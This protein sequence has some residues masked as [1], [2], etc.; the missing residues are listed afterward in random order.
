MD[1]VEEYLQTLESFVASG[2]LHSQDINTLQ[3]R[4]QG[5]I[6]PQTPEDQSVQ[7]SIMAPLTGFSLPL[8]SPETDSTFTELINKQLLALENNLK[9]TIPEL[10]SVTTADLNEKIRQL[11]TSTN[12]T[13][14]LL[15]VAE[16]KNNTLTATVRTLETD[17]NNLEHKI[18]VMEDTNVMLNNTKNTL[19]N[20]ISTL[21]GSNKQLT[22]T[23]TLK[24][25]TLQEAKAELEVKIAKDQVNIEQ[26]NAKFTALQAEID[27]LKSSVSV[28][29]S[30][31]QPPTNPAKKKQ[32]T[33]D[34]EKKQP[35]TNAE[36][37]LKEAETKQAQ[38]VEVLTQEKTRQKTAAADKAAAEK[39]AADKAAAEKA[40]AEKAA[41]D[42][43][44]AEKAAA[45]NTEL[46]RYITALTKWYD[47]AALFIYQYK[48]GLKKW[49]NYSFNDLISILR[50][51]IEKKINEDTK[52]LNK[53]TSEYTGQKITDISSEHFK[54]FSTLFDDNEKTMLVNNDIVIPSSTIEYDYTKST[55]N[56]H[57]KAGLNVLTLMLVDVTSGLTQLTTYN[58]YVARLYLYTE[59]TKNIVPLI[60]EFIVN[61][62]PLQQIPKNQVDLLYKS[63]TDQIHNFK[64]LTETINLS[65]QSSAVLPTAGLYYLNDDTNFTILKYVAK[66]I[67][68]DMNQSIN[69]D[70]EKLQI[71]STQVKEV[72]KLLATLKTHQ[73]ETNDANRTTNRNLQNN[74][75][76]LLVNIS[77]FISNQMVTTPSDYLDIIVKTILYPVINLDKIKP[78]P[79][80]PR[81]VVH[82]YNNIA[83]LVSLW[84]IN[85]I[86]EKIKTIDMAEYSVPTEKFHN[87]FITYIR[88]NFPYE[89]ND[90]WTG[91][92]GLPCIPLPTKAP[93]PP[94]AKTLS[95]DT[96]KWDNPPITSNVVNMPVD[97][98]PWGDFEFESTPLHLAAAAAL[99]LDEWTE[100]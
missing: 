50:T 74:W 9:L 51:T 31:P 86:T 67:V 83:Q 90:Q 53:W 38:A 39:A 68:D 56:D 10:P 77:M 94:I 4:L 75:R 30:S 37:K 44:A 92:G 49:I 78:K 66:H 5:I 26:L 91:V 63:Y 99:N 22:D 41:A 6:N 73:N 17:K 64:P 21:E 29:K 98:I 52:D 48:P 88:N 85:G 81:F 25:L 72:D 35:T 70:K 65:I 97:D 46:Q 24:E 55:A 2:N 87:T 62:F 12:E 43:A 28:P 54:E 93:L 47:E 76:R 42:K 27:K 57:W 95:V 61:T 8:T 84:Q 13:A 40:A 58:F 34:A 19:E 11:E 20:Q 1:K 18:K 80:P 60:T 36:K 82:I 79:N 69:D 45:A 71:N 15:K 32:P 23:F 59:F 3:E 14:K 89:N 7:E 16:A 100:Y 33:T 96:F